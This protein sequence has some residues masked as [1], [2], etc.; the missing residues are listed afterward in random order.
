VTQRQTQMEQYWVDEFQ[1]RQA[2]LDYLY[3]LLLER[4]TPL[5]VDEMALAL[6]RYRFMRE[7]A[8]AAK[9]THIGNVYKPGQHYEV[10]D[11]IAFSALNY[12][13]GKVV[14]TRPGENADYGD[15][16]VLKVEF[17]NAK[18]LEF[19]ADLKNPHA[20]SVDEEETDVSEGD[21][22]S[23]E[24]IFIEYGG[25]VS[26]ALLERLSDHEDLVRL[27][28]RW[29]PRSLL[30]DINVGHLNLAE[31]VLDMVEGGPLP[32]NEIVA[33]LG[34]MEEVNP[35]LAEFSLN[36]GLQQDERFDEV[37]PAGQVL[38]F[39]RRMEP[40]EVQKPPERLVY[41]P[42]SYD[43]GLLSTELRELETAIGDEH[44]AIPV[45]RGPRPQ[46]IVVTLTY[47]HRRAGTLPLSSR[48]RLM[49]PTAY[50]TPH[51]RFTLVDAESGDDIPAWVVRSGGYVYGLSEWFAVHDLP[52]GGYLTIQRTDVPGRVQINYAR[53][54]PRIEWARTAYVENN[55][56]RFENRKR[57]IG[58]DHD[59]LMI[60]DVEDPDEI[61]ALWMRVTERS[62]SLETIMEDVLRQLAPLSQQG[63]VHASTL[64]SAVNLV[65]RCP[66]GPIFAHLVAQPQFEHV[67][68]A[69]WRIA[70]A[71]PEV[72]RD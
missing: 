34:V 60:I 65:R 28:G 63:H 69:Y 41:Q 50:E 13:V 55:R 8:V 44:S 30:A 31:A 23:P 42:I 6:V 40:P 46:S 72:A 5:S 59:D 35:R 38:W 48:L 1:V 54:K 52:V 47:P 56:L 11:E 58:S 71:A 12:R 18:V 37:G 9:Q 32:T 10:G 17:E 61:D 29:F 39:L 20:L 19:A 36:Y 25:Y 7:E 67:G 2:D 62:T 22:L 49:F 24:E 66:P 33:Q 64:Y 43:P 68:G 4:E 21:L 16:S 3:N 53:R 45:Q 14:D 15:F 27:A 70:A 51:I 26:T 57:S